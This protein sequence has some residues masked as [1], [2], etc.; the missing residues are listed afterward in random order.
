MS[1]IYKIY[2]DCFGRSIIILVVLLLSVSSWGQAVTSP[3]NPEPH[4]SFLSFYFTHNSSLLMQDYYTNRANLEKLDE[5]LKDTVSASDM[6]SIII[7]GSASLIGSFEVNSRLSYKRALA[8][9]TY[10]KWKH[11]G[12][13]NDRVKILP[14]V[15]NWNVLIGLIENDPFVPGKDE[16][17][18]ILNSPIDDQS[19]AAQIK[20]LRR[21]NTE[22]YIRR[23]FA[24]DMRMATSVFFTS[25][26][27]QKE[28]QQPESPQVQNDSLPAVIEEV[29]KVNEVITVPEGFPET[30]Y[31]E[32]LPQT[33]LRKP[34]FA[35]KT[36]L[37]FDLV[38]GLNIEV[39]VPLGTRFSLAGEWIFPWWVYEKKQYALEILNGSLELRYWFG[40]RTKD[41]LL[42]GWH[43]GVYGGAGLYDIEWKTK[44]YQGEFIIPFGLSGGFTHKISKNLR[45]EYALGIGYMSNKYREYVPQKCGYDNEWHLIK[46]GQGK[47]T[48]IGPTRA[49][50]SLVWM[51]NR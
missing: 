12:I 5:V 19:K 29:K 34:L 32:V 14:T 31:S 42:T 1:K 45:M 41:N 26:E 6:D 47:N 18:E 21:G 17:L 49:K 36:N 33:K 48:W 3:G 30:E 2:G 37:L 11:P 28:I 4:P 13:Y 25:K 15:F 50:I 51:I 44:G 40:H 46:Q 10:I 22:A 27:I 20:Q 38:S 7:S 24:K 43:M 8:V 16:V 39:E 35:L 9:S 23:N